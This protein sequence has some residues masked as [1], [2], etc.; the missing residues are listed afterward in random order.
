MRL[1]AS[2]GLLVT[3]CACRTP[4][5]PVAPAPRPGAAAA[6]P[7]AVAADPCRGGELTVDLTAPEPDGPVAT[8]RIDREGEGLARPERATCVHIG[9]QRIRLAPGERRHFSI[10]ADPEALQHLAVGGLRLLAHVAAGDEWFL[11]DHPCFFWQLSGPRTDPWFAAPP[12]AYC[13][14]RASRPCRPGFVRASPPRPVHDELCGSTEEIRRCAAVAVVRFAGPRPPA[15][16]EPPDEGISLAELARAGRVEIQ[17][18]DCGF[19]Q[20]ATAT[21]VVGLAVGVGERWRLSLDGDG[22][23]QGVLEP[24]TGRARPRR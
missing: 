5:K 19:F 15:P 22:A 3:L 2:L 24:A 14:S 7:P 4:D 17:P 20:L 16:R 21:E 13:S 11:G 10:R 12:L 8:L 18:R 1:A 23:L 6:K 9:G